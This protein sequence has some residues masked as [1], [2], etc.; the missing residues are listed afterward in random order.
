MHSTRF[1][2]FPP[3]HSSIPADPLEPADPDEAP[4]HDESTLEIE[5]DIDPPGADPE[6]IALFLFTVPV[7][8]M[9][10]VAVLG[11]KVVYPHA[12]TDGHVRVRAN[13]QWD[14][15]GRESTNVRDHEEIIKAET[16]P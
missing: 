6:M 13:I 12:N 5:A 7:L 4:K 10:V 14:M 1:P 9:P 2:P 3:A 11:T 8:L 15:R 16:Q